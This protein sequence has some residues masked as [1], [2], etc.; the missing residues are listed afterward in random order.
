MMGTYRLGGRRRRSKKSQH[1]AVRQFLEEHGRE[2]RQAVRRGNDERH[3]FARKLFDRITD[4]RNLHLAAVEI[5]ARGGK[6]P[7]PDGVCIGDLSEA[8]IWDL[9]RALRDSIG[10]GAYRPGPERVKHVSK[11]AGRG[12]RP[13]VIQNLAD[14]IVQRGTYQILEPFVDPLFAESSFGYRSKLD[15]ADALAFV[16][17]R[18]SLTGNKVWLL[19]DLR[20]AFLNVPHGR[21]LDVV[22]QSVLSEEVTALVNTVI[23]N[24]NQRGLRQGGALSGLLLNAYLNHFLDR[25]W[26]KSHAGDTVIRYADDLLVVCRDD[27]QAAE[28]YDTLTALLRPTGL[29]LK[30]ARSEAIR[31]PAAGQPVRW[32]GYSISIDGSLPVATVS[33]RS[34][35]DFR[36]SLE[37]AWDEPAA[38]L[39]ANQVI[40]GWI[41][42]LGPCFSQ[43][44]HRA[45]YRRLRQTAEEA[46]FNEI[47]SRE[48]V[49]TRWEAAHRRWEKKRDI[50]QD[51]LLNPLAL[52]QMRIGRR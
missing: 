46:G 13:I 2:A 44:D 16:E 7:G 25:P 5:R 51:H 23:S 30:E 35:S 36:D 27:P 11:G 21:L 8:E 29:M 31:H 45:F 10:S 32:L 47:P 15:R 24:Q 18:M 22:R 3:A 12:T 17:M 49:E 34:W 1:K 9:C 48:Q 37:Q 42:Q 6:A 41:D 26:M 40:R 4:E 20:D 43:E 50:W 19:G 28:A 39:V 33:D 52:A 14:R 38:P